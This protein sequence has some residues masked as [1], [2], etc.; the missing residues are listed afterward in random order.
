MPSYRPLVQGSRCRRLTASL[1]P[2]SLLP[3]AA[4]YSPSRSSLCQLRRN[5]IPTLPNEPPRPLGLNADVLFSPVFRR[6]SLSFVPASDAGFPYVHSR[7]I[8]SAH[9]SFFFLHLPSVL[10]PFCLLVGD[11][12]PAFVLFPQFYSGF[13]CCHR[14]LFDIFHQKNPFY[15]HIPKICCTFAPQFKI[16]LL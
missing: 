1:A 6:F 7:R 15:L 4:P 3:S 11:G 12:I 8:L 9:P 16:S 5:C 2:P 10:L 14:I 13:V